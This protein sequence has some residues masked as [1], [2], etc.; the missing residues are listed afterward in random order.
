M[1]NDA[2]HEQLAPE[3]GGVV[4]VEDYNGIEHAVE[5]AQSP[6]ATDTIPGVHFNGDEPIEY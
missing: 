5:M 6:F 4:Y 3:A 2:Q 1:S